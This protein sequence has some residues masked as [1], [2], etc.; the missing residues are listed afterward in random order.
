MNI[1]SVEKKDGKLL[2]TVSVLPVTMTKGR[3]VLVTTELVEQTLQN[4]KVKFGEC[5]SGNQLWNTNPNQ[6]SAQWIF[7]LPVQKKTVA[8]AKKARSAPGQAAKAK[9]AVKLENNEE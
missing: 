7:A 2:V 1:E 3:R 4:Q 8:K 9:T 6:L 5:L